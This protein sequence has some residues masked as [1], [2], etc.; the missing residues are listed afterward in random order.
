MARVQT[1]G[2]ELNSTTAGVEYNGN[3][4]GTGVIGTG[5]VRSGS[6]AF[7]VSGGVQRDGSVELP[8][9]FGP[10]FCRMYVYVAT[11]P[12]SNVSIAFVTNSLHGAVLCSIRLHTDLTLGLEDNHYTQIGS[13]SSAMSLNTWNYIDLYYKNNANVDADAT[14]RLNGS[15]FA[16][17]KTGTNVAAEFVWGNRDASDANLDMWI[18]DIAVNDDTGSFQTSYPGDSKIIALRPNAAGDAN[19]FAVQVGGTA[20]SSNNYTR[21]NEVTPDDAT[22]YNGSAVLSQ[23]DLFNCTDSGINSYDTVNLVN[24]GIRMADL[25]AA[26]ATAAF[27]VEVIKTSGGTKK[28]SSTIIPNSTTWKTNATASPWIYPIIAYQDPDNSNWTQST[29]DSMQVGYTLTA[30]N[31]QTIAASTVWAMIDYTPGTP[32]AATGHLLTLLGAGA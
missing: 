20:G 27:K 9:T 25:V 23:E 1:I 3:V 16:T 5:T 14:G 28:Q 7:H 21:V 30:T 24:V 6:Y 10:Y 19:S 12:A 11:A 15:Q 17:G 31:V 26:D 29:L 8:S 13:L 32:P 4:N 18:D 2:F 22:S